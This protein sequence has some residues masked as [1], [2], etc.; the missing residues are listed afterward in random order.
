MG[1]KL[2]GKRSVAL[3]PPLGYDKSSTSTSIT[4]K[5][6]TTVMNENNIQAQVSRQVTSLAWSPAKSIFTTGLMLYM[7]GNSIQIF[8]IYSTGMA[9]VNPL[10]AIFNA[11]NTFKKFDGQGVDTVFPKLIFIGMQIALLALALW[12]CNSM[13][14]LPMTSADWINYIPIREVAQKSYR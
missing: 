7:T 2:L 9:L 5:P 10:K 1:F 4:D 12:K 14:L 3:P 11:Q 6:E 13:G 8:S